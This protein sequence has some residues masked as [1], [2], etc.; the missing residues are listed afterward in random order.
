MKRNKEMQWKKVKKTSVAN[1]FNI[2]NLYNKTL[3]FI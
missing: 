1:K 2:N 3:A